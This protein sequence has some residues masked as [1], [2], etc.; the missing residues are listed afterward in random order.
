MQKA[1]VTSVRWFISRVTRMLGTL[2]EDTPLDVFVRV[3]SERKL[4]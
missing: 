4:R 3:S 2:L 1:Q